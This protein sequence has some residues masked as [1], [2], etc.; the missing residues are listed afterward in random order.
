MNA[1][2]RRANCLFVKKGIP[3]IFYKN[4]VIF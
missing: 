3:G 1:F 2:A 4:L